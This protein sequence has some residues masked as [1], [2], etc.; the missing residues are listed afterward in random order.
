MANETYWEITFL[1][2]DNIEKV[3]TYNNEVDFYS[4]LDTIWQ[5]LKLPIIN[6]T[7]GSNA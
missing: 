5:E 6:F 4:R 2:V 7:S 3:E 1:D